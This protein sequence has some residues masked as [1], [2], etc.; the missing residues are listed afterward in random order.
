MA[1][2][3]RSSTPQQPQP[4]TE[5]QQLVIQIARDPTV[6]NWLKGAVLHLED[7]D[8]VD[9]LNDCRILLRVQMQRNA[10]DEE[11]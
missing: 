1:T 8:P 5:Y 7:R 9:S 6:S 3:K 11:V 4:L 10:Y 2:Q